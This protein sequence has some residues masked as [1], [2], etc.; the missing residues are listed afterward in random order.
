MSLQILL[1][2]LISIMAL[3]FFPFKLSTSEES[4]KPEFD[5]S[6]SED[7]ETFKAGEVATIKIKVLSNFDKIDKNAFEPTLTVNGKTGNSSY[8]SEVLADFQGDSNNWK[9]FFTT[10]SAGL[11]NVIINE[12]HYHVFDSS[13]HFQV[14]PGRIYPSVCVA[15]WMDYNTEFEAGTRAGIRIL[16]KDAYG[17]IFN[18]TSEDPS[19]YNFTLSALYENGSVAS[20][21]NITHTAWNGFGYIIIEFIVVEA[22]NLFLLVQGGNQT[23]IGS[24]LPIKVTPGPLEISNCVAKWNYEPKAWQ[25]FS[26]MELFLHQQD[27]Y[28]NL[29]PGLYEFDAEVVE[30]ETNLSIPVSDLHF[31]EVSP[32]IQSFSFSN[33]EPGNFFL[34]IS[35]VKHNKSISNMPY[36]Y[37]VFVGYCSGLNSVV[38]GSGLNVSTA[39]EMAEFSVYLKDM[40][41]YPSP[42]EVEWLQVQIEREI[43]SYNVLPSISPFQID[44]ESSIVWG[45]GINMNDNIEIAPSPYANPSNPPIGNPRVLA[46]AFNVVY[47]PDKSGMYGIRVFCGNIQ[48]DGGHSFKMEVRPG[49]VNISLSGVVKFASKVPKLVKNEVEVQLFD[50]FYNPV[51]SQQSRLKLEVNSTNNSSI[52]SSWMFVDNNNRSYTSLYEAEKI[53]TY[54]ICASFDGKPFSPCPFLVN[55]YSG[56]YFPRAFDDSIYVWEDESIAFDVLE[57]DYFAGENASVVGFSEPSHGSL[58]Q[59]GKLLL[60]TPHKDYYGN[61]SFTYEMSDINGNVA[62]AAVN[63][64]V[65]IIP[66]QFVFFPSQLQATEDKISP[67]FGGFLG[68]ELRY[69]DIVE[70]ISVTLSAKFGSICLSPMPMQFWPTN[71]KLSAYKK[72][73]KSLVLE[74]TVEVVNFALKS[75]QY[76]GNENFFG[77]DSV[78][79]STKNTKGVNNLDVPLFVEPINDPPFI[80]VPAFIILNSSEDEPLIYDRERDKFEFSIG[81][82]DLHGFPGAESDFKVIFSVEVDNG[83]LVTSLPAEFINSTELRTMNTYQWQ[84]LQTYVTISQHFTVRANGVRFH[85]TIENCNSVMKQL[86]YRG[87]EDGTMLRVTVNDM[88]NYGCFLDCAEKASMPLYTEAAV[89]LIRRRP[90]TSFLSHA[91]GSAVVIESIMVS[92]LGG[93]LLFFTCKCAI[94]LVSQRKKNV[95]VQSLTKKSEMTCRSNISYLH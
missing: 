87:E 64:S 54:N 9:I 90:M 44:N 56:E 60:Y 13:L 6:W 31:E 23:L 79:V 5:F 61:D 29:V 15:S 85:G 39:G 26:K 55:V 53:G 28:G 48:L 58:L 30:K 8:V 69:S 89:N 95:I 49:E 45:M 73:P 83:F 17:N 88:G 66:P 19:K 21:P 12:D 20:M 27:Q 32:G 24:P 65:L 36:A 93:L 42:I 47:T 50:S 59:H 51:L 34:T 4:T 80:H 84:P 7:K 41:H 10:I 62:T 67:R 71:S 2:I 78:R 63:I 75:I 38:N 25:L 43:D 77:D 92:S 1:H 91:L 3:S 72:E 52:S 68:F 22:G 14:Q 11:F 86:F 81:D 35:D 94:V 40:Y 37:S 70:N 16:P 33:L 46:T 76:L 57:N 82:P 74:G 18:S